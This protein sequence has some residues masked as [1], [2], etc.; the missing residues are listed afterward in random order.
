[1]CHVADIGPAGQMRRNTPISRYIVVALVR[2]LIRFD[3]L[4]GLPVE[5]AEAEVQWATRGA[6]VR[7]PGPT[8]HCSGARRTSPRPCLRRTGTRVREGSRCGGVGRSELRSGS[9]FGRLRCLA[10]ARAR[11]AYQVEASTI[12]E[13]WVLPRSGYHL[14][15][16]RSGRRTCADADDFVKGRMSAERSCARDG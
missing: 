5:L 10:K 4:P 16:A 1:M 7:R 13:S 11:S 6:L 3:P 12:S 9:T 14:L 15:S 2:V 8:R